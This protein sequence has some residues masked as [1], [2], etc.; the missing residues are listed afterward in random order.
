MLVDRIR[1]GRYGGIISLVREPGM[2]NGLGFMRFGGLGDM[3]NSL[4]GKQARKD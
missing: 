4:Y 1:S 3:A 2:R